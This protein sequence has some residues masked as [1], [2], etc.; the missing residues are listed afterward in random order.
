MNT[1]SIIEIKNLKIRLGGERIHDNLHLTVNRGEILGIVGGSGSGKTT[2]LP[3][4]R[5]RKMIVRRT[6]R[7]YESVYPLEILEGREVDDHSPT[8]SPHLHLDS[9]VEVRRQQLLELQH[10]GSR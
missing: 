6:I 9:C 3:S 4:R 1:K 10:S 7:Y 2:L 5:L 8:L